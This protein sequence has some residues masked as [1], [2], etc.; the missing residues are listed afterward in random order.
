MNVSYRAGIFLLG[1]SCCS[2]PVFAQPQAGSTPVAVQLQPGPK[3]PSETNL[4]LDVV[5]TDK[6]GNAVKSLEEKDFAVFDNGHPQKI[7]SFHATG[8][9]V[10]AANIQPAEPVKIILMVDEVNTDFRRVAYERDQIK[11][12]LQ[13]NNGILAHPTSMAFFTDKGTEVQNTTSRDGNAL[14]EAFDQHETALRSIR[15]DQGF[16][17]AVERFQL[18]L[19][20]LN[21]LVT[22]E[23]QTP[24]RKM[25]IWI[26]PGWPILSGPNIELSGKEQAALF[27]SIVAAS[28]AMRE[29]RMTLYSV[30]P[31]GADAAGGIQAFYYREFLKPVTS[32]N[33]VLPGDL[34]LQVLALQSGGLA[35]T[36]SN[37]IAG[38]IA[39]CIA[40][41]DAFYTLT[42]DP[43][44]AEKPNEYHAIEVKV[45]RPG[46][47]VRTRSGYYAQ[48]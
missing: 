36:A 21:S 5:V 47:T 6:T 7:L 1:L 44:R 34:A 33:R 10:A 43:A 31:Q 48:P 46:L 40:D 24:G 29:A 3:P 11:K 38:Q 15:R 8:S 2:L 25:V 26:S 16:Y 22:R 13:Q 35:F 41:A 32:A 30:D 17:G 37:D 39:R 18:S 27:A 28:T 23:A 9:G 12:L 20:T 42:L 4:V 19:S 45:A 14:L